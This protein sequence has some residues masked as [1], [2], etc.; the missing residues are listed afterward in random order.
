MK[1][2]MMFVLV[3]LC[4]GLGC[5]AGEP[6]GPDE[7]A[8]ETAGQADEEAVGEAEQAI[9][10]PC[11]NDCHCPLTERC[12]PSYYC[13]TYAVWGP[14]TSPLKC[15]NNCQCQ[16]YL[17]PNYYCNMDSGSYGHCVAW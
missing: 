9:N 15:V 4:L 1:P 10:T 17:A 7:T 6:G 16:T 2:V 13:T 11:F 8:E 14:D 5:T 3:S 12:S